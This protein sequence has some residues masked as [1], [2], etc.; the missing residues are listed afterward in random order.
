MR[1]VFSKIIVFIVKVSLFK[2]CES[3]TSLCRFC[4]YKNE[5]MGIQYWSKMQHLE[6]CPRFAHQLVYDP[7]H[8]VSYHLF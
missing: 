3:V 6:P 5:N 7:V 1:H 2:I 8:K 4:V